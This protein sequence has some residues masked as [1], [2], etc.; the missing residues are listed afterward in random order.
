MKATSP[1]PGELLNSSA[2]GNADAAVSNTD[3]DHDG[4]VEVVKQSSA[5]II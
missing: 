4:G 1:I 5:T 3:S 2:S